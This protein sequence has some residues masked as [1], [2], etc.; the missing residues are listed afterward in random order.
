[1]PRNLYAHFR[2]YLLASLLL[3]V[4]ATFRNFT[5]DDSDPS[6]VYGPYGAW[7]IGNEC[8]GCDAQPEAE[9]VYN[10]TWHD[11]AFYAP[12][13]SQTMAFPNEPFTAN[14]TFNGTAIYVFCIMLNSATY[15]IFGDSDMIFHMDG[16]PVST[17]QNTPTEN[18][19]TYTYNVPVFAMPSLE[20]G[21]HRLMIQ[22]GV[23]NGT[24]AL[25]LLDYIIFTA[26]DDLENSTNFPPPPTLSPT[27]TS[28]PIFPPP[29]STDRSN[30]GSASP[31]TST[32]NNEH[33]E[34]ISRA[35]EIALPIGSVLLL[36]VISTLI[37]WRRRCSRLKSQNRNPLT[38]A[39]PVHLFH[40]A[41]SPRSLPPQK[42]IR[43]RSSGDPTL[44]GT[45]SDYLLDQSSPTAMR[46]ITASPPA[47]RATA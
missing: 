47:Y 31:L 36:L 20:Y 14:I 29:A 4:K 13:N 37:V 42:H 45:N 19:D 7:N 6:W 26:D 21:L 24:N 15:P 2:L 40:I 46:M 27:D 3:D 12:P 22:N 10:Q 38:Q 30:S 1:M 25:I 35:L 8:H 5:I 18:L 39:R 33:A 16:I 9:L 32:E 43:Y 17:Y 11:A 34:R 44:G 28:S 41:S 23:P